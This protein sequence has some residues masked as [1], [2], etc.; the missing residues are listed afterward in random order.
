MSR[1]STEDHVPPQGFP[2]HLGKGDRLSQWVLLAAAFLTPSR[3]H[4]VMSRNPHTILCECFISLVWG[5]LHGWLMAARTWP[6]GAGQGGRRHQVL[7][8]CN[9][10]GSVLPL[11]T[12]S[13]GKDGSILCPHHGQLVSAATLHSTTPSA[14][15]SQQHLHPPG[16]GKCHHSV[17]D[18]CWDWLLLLCLSWCSWAYLHAPGA[19][20]AMP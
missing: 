15:G 20:R 10:A 7:C 5:V 9:G 8:H 17:Q 4:R 12:N 6:W 3:F 16:F 19:V 1:G 13:L 2:S 14:R 11:R 18:V